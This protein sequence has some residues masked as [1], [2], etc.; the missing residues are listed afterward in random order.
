M[1]DKNSNE[2]IETLTKAGLTSQ[3][4]S[5][6]SALV[7]K[8]SLPA[9]K[10]ALSIGLSRPLTYKVL[11]ELVMV[12]L[13]DKQE[14]PGTVAIFTAAHPLKLKDVTDRRLL[15]AQKAQEALDSTL[16]K[17]I[18]AFNLVSGMPGIRFFEGKEGIREVMNDALTS[19]TE[20]YSYVDIDAVEKE[21]PD[22]SREFAKR[23]Q[24]LGLMKKNIGVD[25][26]E[27]RKAIDGYF[28]DVT[29]ERLIPWPTAA[30][31]T[32][33]QIYD[34]KVSYFTL[35]DK[36]IGVIIADPHIYEM[37]HS[38]F[39]FT[40]DSPRIYKPSSNVRKKLEGGS[41]TI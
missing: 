8:G 32:V 25:T 7:Q 31:G 2:Y 14:K 16:P 13:V 17:L 39:E 9:S 1:E 18:S 22:I 35:G 6:Y 21:I 15:N 5:V 38:L 23:R 34:G 19:K 29:E 26:P 12:A 3:Q 4:A 10:V 24:K 30:F 20:I 28:A 33:M 11:D 27:N 40:W 37:H 36:M 41:D